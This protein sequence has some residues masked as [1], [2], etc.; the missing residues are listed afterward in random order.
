MGVFG[1]LKRR[2]LIAQAS[3][4]KE[5][6]ELLSDA[7]NPVKFYIGFDATADSLHVGHLVQLILMRHLQKAGH[8]PYALLGT[9]TTLVGDPSGKTDMRQMLTEESIEHNAEKFGE[10][11]S[12]F[13]DFSDNCKNAAE[14]VKNGD[15]LLGLKY[16]EFIRDI[17]VHFTVNRMLAAECFKSR[18]EKGLSFFEFNYMLIQSYDFLHL[19]KTKEVTLQIGGDDQWSNIL[20]G[21]DLIRR[22]EQKSAFAMTTSLL[23]TKD[24][25]KMGKTLKGALWLNGEKCP[26]YEFYQ[27][28]RNVDDADVVNCLK[29][30][31]F[32]PIDE[33]EEM[34]KTLEG[35]K[36]NHAK[37]L[38]AFELTKLVHGEE[39]AQ[40]AQNAAKS[41]F[42][43]GNADEN[44]PAVAVSEAEINILDLL[45]KAG[46]CNSKRD[47]RTNTEQGGVSVNDEKITDVNTVVKIDDF[48]VVKKGKKSFIKVIRE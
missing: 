45:I 42:G 30:L 18:M 13:L 26:P 46:L 3:H 12:R 28:F 1:E 27:Y 19:F 14:F 7:A 41:I 22:K 17:G 47:A 44:M 5:I 6:E 20:A 38:L 29:M 40:K 11:M 43:A 35:A 34:E 24:G 31:T 32:V 25:A 9:G 48:V 33:I 37:E 10:Q 21:A 2:G 39:E 23:L 4:E 36:F 15:W 16:V 8:K